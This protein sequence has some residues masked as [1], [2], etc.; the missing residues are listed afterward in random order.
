M[1]LSHI[2]GHLAR[3]DD[4]VLKN[5]IASWRWDSS[6]YPKEL[7]SIISCGF[8]P[9]GTCLIP[10]HKCFYLDMHKF[11]SLDV[12]TQNVRIWCIA[13]G[14]Y[15]GKTSS[16]QFSGDKELASVTSCDFFFCHIFHAPQKPPGD[17]SAFPHCPETF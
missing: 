9:D 5:P 2:L 10:W 6:K 4:V 15:R 1:R 12:A 17:S 16:A 13:H 7:V 3:W 8:Y 14:S 11:R